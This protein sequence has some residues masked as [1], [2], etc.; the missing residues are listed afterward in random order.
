MRD[1][2]ELLGLP[3]RALLDESKLQVAWHQKSREAHP[4]H[5][6]GSSAL[7]AEVNA[8]YETLLAPEK[9]LKHLLELHEVRG[10][11]EVLVDGH[12]ADVVQVG[13][14]HRRAVDL[15]LHHPSSHRSAPWEVDADRSVAPG[16]NPLSLP[17]DFCTS[18]NP[19]KL[20]SPLPLPH[21]SP[22]SPELRTTDRRKPRSPVRSSARRGGSAGEGVGQRAKGWVGGRTL[23][24]PLPDGQNSKP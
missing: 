24:R 17:P 5:P 15:R 20:T 13:V 9:R 11:H 10:V 14:G 4:D 3:R 6:G 18:T 12:R 22:T 1:C 21:L 23:R 8:A 16:W 19:P 2:F 7:A